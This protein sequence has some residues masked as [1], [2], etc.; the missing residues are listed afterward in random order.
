MPDLKFP[1]I[2]GI[3]KM[4]NAKSNPNII[5]SFPRCKLIGLSTNLTNL[6]I[7]NAKNVKL[8]ILPNWLFDQQENLSLE[9]Y[10]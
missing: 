3:G 1:G 5:K 6:L 8:H 7:K 9:F 10:D 2:R 4:K